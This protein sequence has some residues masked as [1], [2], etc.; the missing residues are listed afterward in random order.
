MVTNAVAMVPKEI[1][2][3]TSKYTSTALVIRDDLGDRHERTPQNNDCLANPHTK[4]TV[5][6]KTCHE[7]ITNRAAKT[8][9]YH[10]VKVS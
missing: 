3:S 2:R 1:P 7:H 4:N 10:P 8:Y 9:T 5:P 6:S